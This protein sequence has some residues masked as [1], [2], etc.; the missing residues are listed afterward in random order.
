VQST[1]KTVDPDMTL[2]LRWSSATML[3]LLFVFVVL[4]F[5]IAIKAREAEVA[6]P[7]VPAR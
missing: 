6:P 4:R 2:V 5:R 7:P 3:A 1:P